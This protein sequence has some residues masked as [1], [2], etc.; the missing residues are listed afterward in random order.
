MTGDTAGNRLI[1]NPERIGIN[2][3]LIERLRHRTQCCI[4]LLYTSGDEA[5]LALGHVFHIKAAAC[6]RIHNGGGILR[7]APVCANDKMCIRDRAWGPFA[8]GKKNCFT[9]PV[10][11]EIGEKYGKTAAQTALRF[12][13]LEMLML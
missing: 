2:P 6:K 5:A 1:A 4:C 3:V 13:I 9:N 12:L 7:D 10:L 11:A 8:E